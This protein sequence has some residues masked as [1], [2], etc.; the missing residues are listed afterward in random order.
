MEYAARLRSLAAT[1]A[2]ELLIIMQVQL[3]K[4]ATGA[5]RDDQRPRHGR[6][7]PD[8]QGLPPGAAAAPRHQPPGLAAATK[9]LD[10]ISPQFVA[11]LISWAVMSEPPP[12]APRTA[13]S[14]LPSAPVGF[15]N[16]S[17]G[18][19][20]VAIDAVRRARSRTLCRVEAGLAGIVET[21]GNRDCHVVLQGGAGPNHWRRRWA[22]CARSRRRSCRRA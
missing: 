1:H 13:S 7:V 12:R 22:R 6:L 3:D 4:P 10:T 16:A 19:T 18:D 11:D 8:Q 14:P 2:G 15:R 20:K 21:S 17:S 9:Y 5:E